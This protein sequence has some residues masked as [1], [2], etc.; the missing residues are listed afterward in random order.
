MATSPATD[1]YTIGKAKLYFTQATPSVV[2]ERALGNAPEVEF[3]PATE[4][5][6]H[7]SSMAGVRSKD[8]SVV[9]E[10]SAELRM[11][12]DEITAQNL[13]MLMVGGAVSAAASDG[14]QSF[15][16]FAESEITGSLRIEGT[17]DIGNK[18]DADFPQVSI[19]PT[20][21]YSFISDEWAQMEMTADVL[22][23]T[24]S[25]GTSDFG[26]IT[27]TPQAVTP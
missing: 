4:T 27:V 21:S 1:N 24:H 9:I 6:D 3:T 16:I 17:N 2:A 22:L 19:K 26:T 7:F 25:D 20:G 14:G 10:K 15:A 18:V 11:V 23:Q 8:K 13:Q 12:L 5:L